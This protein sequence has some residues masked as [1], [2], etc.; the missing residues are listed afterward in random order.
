MRA[1]VN[2]EFG[3]PD[4][5]TVEEVS[6]VSPAPDEVLIR[7]AGAGV[8]RADILQREGH[9]P[10]PD[11]ASQILGLECSGQ[12]E[13][14]GDEVD[15]FEVGDEVCALLPGG[16]YAELVTV[17]AN[18][19][20][21]RPHG[22]GLTE[23]AALPETACTVWSNVF[24]LG[25]LSPTETLLVHGGT[26][27]IGT[28]AIPLA[29]LLGAQVITTAG[30]DEKVARCRELGADVA[31]NYRTQDFVAEVADATDGAGAN[32][33][34]DIVGA[35]YL[36]RNVEALATE[37]RLVVI[38][39]QGGRRGEL[40]LAQLLAKRAGVFASGLRYRP[41]LEKATVVDSVR[42]HVWPLL[43]DGHLSPVIHD[44]LPFEE[45]GQA[46]RIMEASEHIGK[47]VLSP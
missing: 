18:H 24:M 33:I 39:L 42:E 38:G 13:Q 1:V 2:Q 6:D 25:A 21:R 47:L 43:D 22:V 7:V 29:K 32:V 3:G 14:L 16:G 46:H 30:T 31:I 9:Y 44:I 10:P 41:A 37:G 4:V 34:L 5:L 8:N 23:A 35:S 19:V 12:V 27:G 15:G 45:A 11:G 26:S 40:D 36:P 20:L 17:T 28:M